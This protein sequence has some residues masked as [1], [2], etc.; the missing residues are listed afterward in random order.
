MKTGVILIAYKLFTETDENGLSG[1]PSH[2]FEIDSSE[3]PDYADAGFLTNYP[4]IFEEY[5]YSLQDAYTNWKN[6]YH[7]EVM[8]VKLVAL[9]VKKENPTEPPFDIDFVSGLDIKLHRKSII[10]KGE[11]VAEEYYESF[12]NGQYTNLI[13]REESLYSRDLLGFPVYKEVKIKYALEGGGYH[14]REKT[15][16]KYY[17]SLEQIQEGKTRRGNLIANIQMPTIGLISIAMIGSTNATMAVISE[18]R[19]FLAAYKNEFETFISDSN[20]DILKCFTDPAFPRYMTAQDWPWIDFYTPY[21][22]TIRQY[23]ASEIS[24]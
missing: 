19:K 3:E 7:P 1:W 8:R 5:K 14:T 17:S 13:I 21:G 23:L 2:S 11:C 9:T 10:V 24:I 22:I 15:W 12:I 18:G 16:R 6:Q 20:R 4:H